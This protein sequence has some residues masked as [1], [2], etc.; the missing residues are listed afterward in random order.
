M[1]KDPV[2]ETEADAHPSGFRFVEIYTPG[3]LPS[4]LRQK[5]ASDH[6]LRQEEYLFSR[7]TKATYRNSIIS[8]LARLKKR[9]PA[10]SADDAGTLE[11][12]AARNAV[13]AEEAKGRLTRKRVEAFVHPPDVLAKFDYVV[14]VPPGPGADTPSEEGNMRTCERCKR[15]YMVS[16]RLSQ[17]RLTRL[18]TS[19]LRWNSSCALRGPVGGRILTPCSLTLG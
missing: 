12:E 11:D 8:A 1:R 9:P 15:E 13:L 14:A 16:S 4:S 6:A 17:V 2:S 3:V 5:L 18:Q 7:S 10:R 19:V